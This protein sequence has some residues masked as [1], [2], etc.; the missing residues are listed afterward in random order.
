MLQT[1]LS[2]AGAYFFVGLLLGMVLN[3]PAIID[4]FKSKSEGSLDDELSRMAVVWFLLIVAWPLIAPL[5]SYLYAADRIVAK[6]EKK[7]NRRIKKQQV[8]V[9]FL[10]YIRVIDEDLAGDSM[11][12]FSCKSHEKAKKI[13]KRFGV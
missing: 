7:I 13:R 2:Y 11:E 6:L 3:T 4:I 10:F 1:I 9:N 8:L 5:I 12:D